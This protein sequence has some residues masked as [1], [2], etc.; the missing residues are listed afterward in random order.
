MVPKVD[1]FTACD[2]ITIKYSYMNP[3]IITTNFGRFWTLVITM[4]MVVPLK[5]SIS[6]NGPEATWLVSSSGG[7]KVGFKVSSDSRGRLI[8]SAREIAGQ[9][10]FLVALGKPAH[11]G[12][13]TSYS[14]TYKLKDGNSFSMRM[15]KGGRIS[16]SWGD[17]RIGSVKYSTGTGNTPTAQNFWQWIGD[18]V[19][20]IVDGIA[21]GIIYLQGGTVVME[22]SSGAEWSVNGGRS[23][24]VRKP[25]GSFKLEPGME[26]EGGIWY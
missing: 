23:E 3:Y 14:T 17:I 2:S 10:L 13:E 8:L 22:T 1:S 5:A 6:S 20:D 9:K 16:C 15:D 25:A 11:E 12:K 24:I 26:E 7:K 4:L 19:G 18:L 21:A